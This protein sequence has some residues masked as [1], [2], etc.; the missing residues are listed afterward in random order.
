LLTGMAELLPIEIAPIAAAA[1]KLR[2]TFFIVKSPLRP[3]CQ[4]GFRFRSVQRPASERSRYA[5]V[6]L[7]HANDSESVPKADIPRRA[8]HV[9]FQG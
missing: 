6:P 3:N 7:D 5:F 4:K 8:A 9:R 1:S 2:V